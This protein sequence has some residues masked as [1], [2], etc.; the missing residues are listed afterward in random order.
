MESNEK[1]KI[2]KNISI[3]KNSNDIK[4]DISK[5][6]KYFKLFLIVLIIILVIGIVIVLSVFLKK[7]S[8]KS[9]NKEN[10]KEKIESENKNYINA[11][12]SVQ[13]G[14]QVQLF[15][16]EKIGVKDNDYKVEI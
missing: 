10:Q 15:N 3:K 5:K 9:D 2:E 7:Y 8:K 16:P 13:S 1:I 4:I 12:Y 14:K 6:N 11:S